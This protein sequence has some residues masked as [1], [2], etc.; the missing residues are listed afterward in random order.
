MGRNVGDLAGIGVLRPEG[1]GQ[2]EKGPEKDLRNPSSD[3]GVAQ[4]PAVPKKKTKEP[5]AKR[6]KSGKAAGP[7]LEPELAWFNACDLR[8]GKIVECQECP[9]SE[10]LMEEKIDLGEGRLRT[11]GSGVRPVISLEE[12]KKEAFVMVFAN[13]K[14]RKLG[15]ILSHGM[16]MCASNAAHDDFELLR[17]AA[18]AT[19]GERIMLEGNPIGDAF[20]QEA[21]PELK[22]KNMKKTL[23]K[24]LPLLKTNEAGEAC[25]NGIRLVTSGGAPL[26][27]QRLTDSHID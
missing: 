27:V 2:G 23:K 3:G 5:K 24:L 10:K 11:I 8:V 16:V 22:P 4:A 19:L 6:G 18:D 14:A 7:T 12:M 15:P 21:Q 25:Y 1:S 26:T 17:P 20:S 9:E 13:L